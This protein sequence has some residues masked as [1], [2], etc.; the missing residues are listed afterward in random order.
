M[1]KLLTTVLF[2]GLLSVFALPAVSSAALPPVLTVKGKIIKI[3]KGVV[4]LRYKKSILK[5]PRRS[6]KKHQL[7][8]GKQ[9]VV[10][11]PASDFMKLN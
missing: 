8:R 4:F 6:I 11:I 2:S 1:K 10:R 9:V 7:R 5:V 3:K